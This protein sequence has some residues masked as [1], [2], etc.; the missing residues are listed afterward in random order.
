MS[1]RDQLKSYFRSGK[2]PTEQ[3]FAELIDAMALKAELPPPPPSPSP[4][5]VPPPHPPLPPSPPP[6]PQGVRLGQFDPSAESRPQPLDRKELMESCRRPADGQWY[7][8]IPRL[9]DCYAFEVVACASGMMK[10][11]HHAVTHAIALTS[12]AAH[13][14][15]RQ[16]FSQEYPPIGWRLWR[17][18]QRLLCQFLRHRCLRRVE[19]RWCR[20]GDGV[21]LE[22]RSNTSFGRDHEGAQV[23]IACHITRLW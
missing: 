16:T 7:P 22:V 15:V 9:N 14:N 23:A 13:A 18:P 5:P 12:F 11:G 6:L 17:W 21:T 3:Q 1:P 19:F 4:P 10:P 8:L 2:V 20:H